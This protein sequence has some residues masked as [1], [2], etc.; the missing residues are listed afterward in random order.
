MAWP[1]LPLISSPVTGNPFVAAVGVLPVTV[2][3]GGTAVW[4][5]PMA[6]MPLIPATNPY[7]VAGNPYIITGRRS[8]PEIN[9]IVRALAHHISGCTGGKWQHGYQYSKV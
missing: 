9:N 5:F 8:G 4:S 1:A 7:P 3:P 6:F 2:Y